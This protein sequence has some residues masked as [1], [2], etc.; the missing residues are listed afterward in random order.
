MDI[1]GLTDFFSKGSTLVF[2]IGFTVVI[3]LLLIAL[4]FALAR[5]VGQTRAGIAVCVLVS[6][7]CFFPLGVLLAALLSVTASV[8]FFFQLRKFKT[9]A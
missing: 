3:Y 4:P 6:V 1:A 8:W 5:A 7:L 2:A 9:K